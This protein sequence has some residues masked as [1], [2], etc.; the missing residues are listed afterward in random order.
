MADLQTITFKINWRLVN[1]F[2]P[3]FSGYAATLA[4][5][6]RAHYNRTI[7]VTGQTTIKRLQMSLS[8]RLIRFYQR[9]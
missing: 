7:T 4:P 2:S 3:R 8:L 9:G 1:H 5:L 6:V